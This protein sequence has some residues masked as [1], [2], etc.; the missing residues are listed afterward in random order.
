MKRRRLRTPAAYPSHVLDPPARRAR[1]NLDAALIDLLQAR[2][3]TP[4]MSDPEPFT[5]NSREERALAAQAC[6]HCPVLVPCR[7]YAEAADERCF[8][9]A[10]QDRTPDQSATAVASPMQ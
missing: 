9:W 8:V 3:S 6:S 1:A 5:S 4:C 10:G 2:R 7:A